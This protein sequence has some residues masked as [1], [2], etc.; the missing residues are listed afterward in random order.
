VI[1]D[2]IRFPHTGCRD[3]HHITWGEVSLLTIVVD[4][5]FVCGVLRGPPRTG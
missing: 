5:R 3:C 4:S 2:T 1:D